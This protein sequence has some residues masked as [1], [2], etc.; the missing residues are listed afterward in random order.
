M[1][2][3]KIISHLRQNYDQTLGTYGL[4]LHKIDKWRV[5][6]GKK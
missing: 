6:I 3:Q 1:S 5:K 2:P 4:H